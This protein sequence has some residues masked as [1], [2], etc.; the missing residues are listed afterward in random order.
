M[1]SGKRKDGKGS[2]CEFCWTN[3]GTDP[4]YLRADGK[5]GHDSKEWAKGFNVTEK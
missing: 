1:G 5:L 4:E 2:G 3:L